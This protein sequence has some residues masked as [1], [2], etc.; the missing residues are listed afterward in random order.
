MGVKLCC[1][2]LS[3]EHRLR[4]FENRV[5]R[6]IFGPK[7]NEATWEWRKLHIYDLYSSPNIVWVIKSIRMRIMGRVCGSGEAYTLFW[8]RNLRERDHFEDP[9]IDGR[10]I[11]RWI[12]RKWDLEVWTGWIK[13]RIGI[14]C[15]HL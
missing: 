11:L 5:S 13:L 12:L 8:W 2:T 6:R 9:G 3:E 4:V 10:I 7:R 1:L 14:G 15:G